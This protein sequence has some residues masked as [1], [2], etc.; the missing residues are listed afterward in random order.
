MSSATRTDLAPAADDPSSGWLPRIATGVVVLARRRGD[1]GLR[2]RRDRRGSRRNLLQH[3]DDRLRGN[4][5]RPL[6]RRP[7]HHLHLPA[8]RNRRR[9]RRGH[10]NRK[11]RGGIGRDR[12]HHARRH[13]GPLEF[14]RSR[15]AR[16][17]AQ[18]ARG[19]WRDGHRHPRADD[20]DPRAGHAE[21]GHRPFARRGL[22]PRRAARESGRVAR[23]RRD[24]PRSGGGLDPAL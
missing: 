9:Q 21:R 18:S 6:L 17:L 16:Q 3:G 11:S 8:Y 1:R 5:D 10:R 19:R 24:G 13:F 14:P 22:R 7:D 20:A 4:P 23:H 12:R 2:G 15:A